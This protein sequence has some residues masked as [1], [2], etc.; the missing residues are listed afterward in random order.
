MWNEKFFCGKMQTN[1]SIKTLTPHFANT[2]CLLRN[3]M[4][5]NMENG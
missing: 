5:N 3:C 2:M 4:Y 1:F